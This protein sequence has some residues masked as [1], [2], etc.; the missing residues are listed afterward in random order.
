MHTDNVEGDPRIFMY[1]VSSLW[2]LNVAFRCL[3]LLDF[4]DFFLQL[5]KASTYVPV[6]RAS[7]ESVYFGCQGDQL[8]MFIYLGVVG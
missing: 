5:R 7:P 8:Q 4:I 1:M 6:L 3:E 2:K